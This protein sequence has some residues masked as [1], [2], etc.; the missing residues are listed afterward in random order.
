MQS[1]LMCGYPSGL[2]GVC[3]CL[4]QCSADELGGGVTVVQLLA[5]P[6]FLV[7]SASI[8][9][10]DFAVLLAGSCHRWYMPQSQHNT[11]VPAHGVLRAWH[12]F[13]GPPQRC[14]CGLH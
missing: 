8:G 4:S 12:C 2:C 9:L 14:C 3:T 7:S 10:L 1:C 5:R 13:M 6:M 11:Y